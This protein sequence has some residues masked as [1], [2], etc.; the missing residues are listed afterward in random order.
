MKKMMTSMIEHK[1]KALGRHLLCLGI[2]GTPWPAMGTPIMG[3]PA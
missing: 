3:I 2:I 1:R